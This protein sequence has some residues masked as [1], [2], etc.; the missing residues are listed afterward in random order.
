[1]ATR[2]ELGVES[3]ELIQHLADQRLVVTGWDAAG[4]ETAE[5][6]HEALIQKWDRFRDWMRSDHT[7]RLWQERLRD[8]LRQWQESGEDEGA[9]LHG[10]PLSVAQEWLG[11]RRDDLGQ[12][13]VEYIRQSQML[14]ARLQK[15]RQGRR[16]WTVIGLSAGLV[17]AIVLAGFAFYQRQNALRQSAI[18]LAGQAETELANGYHDRAVLLALAALENYPYTS[19]A[20]HALGQAVSY[21]RAQQ[22]YTEH[23]S[24]ATSVAWSP[25]GKRVASSSSTD[26]DVHIWDP[27]TG[28]TILVIDMPKGITGNKFD[29]ALHMQWTPDGKRLL[30]VTGDRYTLGS[31]DYDLLLWDAAS[32]ALISRV[33]IANQA[34]PE[35]GELSVTDHNYS[36]GAAAEIAQHNGRL[37]SLGGDNT[38]LIWDA[39]WQK[40]EVVLIGHTK[41][42]NSIDWSP[43][44]TRLAT[45]SL[46]GTAIIWDA[47][48]G[49]AVYR[50]EGHQ[51]R[52][53][54]A[55]WS[56]DGASL[57]TAGEDGTLRIWNA[58]D[59]A[60]L[61]SIE[62]N[63]GEVSS[64][65]WAPNSVRIVSGHA[66]GS[67]HIWETATGKLLETLRG[68][69][70]D[71]SD[72]KWSPVDDRL[73]SADGSGNVQV[74]NA[75]PSTA[76]RLYPPQAARGG[77]WSVQGAGW[78]SDGRYLAMAGGDIINSTEPPS[79]AI[80]DVQP[81]QLLMEN[82]G[83]ALNF[84]G[85]EAQFSPDDQAILYLGTTLFPDFSG[86]ATAYVF[87]AKS[88][89]IIRTFTSSSENWIRSA[90]WSPDG[91]Q[92]AGGLINNQ[93]I[94][95]DYQTGEQ[96]TR[97]VESNN[98]KMFINYVEWSPDGSK[99]AAASDESTARVWD[100]HTWK[101]LY[102][103][104]HEPPAYVNSV[105]WSPDGTRLLTASG[106]DEQG[107]KDN[108]ARVWDAATGKELLVFSGHTKS[109]WPGDWSPDGKRIATAS[110]DGTVRVWDAASGA[111]V[112]RLSIPVSYGV[113]AR[114]SPDGQH[115]AVVGL[116]SLV[117]VWR[118]WQ[119]K[120]ELVDYAKDCCVIRQPTPAERQQF[121]LQ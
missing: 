29:M 18:L 97:L 4:V 63:A 42:V 100:A 89:E 75:A 34:E 104:Q 86:F 112:L 14:Q 85:L 9:L 106:N 1:V 53:N 61:R 25:D 11:E 65:A 45:S 23:Q 52:V 38:A 105:T 55:L 46:D 93:I 32:G 116:E 73:A 62:T 27:I 7:F 120:Q 101:P 70:G 90:A 41:S 49:K 6:V 57:A 87:D 74:W 108:T 10:A 72:L 40:P 79:F 77:N 48:T 31:Q 28:K 88:G 33:E 95:W 12:A 54:L 121:G 84:S 15:E 58:A 119:T 107:A 22:I 98:E 2:A 50:L 96:I 51:G 69:Q 103:L 76:W 109:V 56:P 47:Q 21:S 16:Q 67:L 117:S 20:E 83:D 115:L 80:W 82:L 114:W 17:I 5:V 64:L 71:V 78:S 110:N 30:T 44:E 113:L 66:D 24:A 81:N 92:V 13:E 60:L 102:T 43:D 111:E 26:N 68:H 91:S 118:V 35:S 8:Q 59:G 3:W 36:T 39:A 99:I 94:I 19:Q 37:A